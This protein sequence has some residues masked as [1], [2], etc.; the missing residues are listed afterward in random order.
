MAENEVRESKLIN[1]AHDLAR[2]L[3]DTS[4]QIESDDARLTI[5]D[6]LRAWICM[7]CGALYSHEWQGCHCRN[8]E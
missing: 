5:F 2:Q 3:L 4:R 6:V 1:K 7:Y 8:D